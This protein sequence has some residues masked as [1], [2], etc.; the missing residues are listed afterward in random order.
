M[1][2]EQKQYER[3]FEIIEA[4]GADSAKWPQDGAF[5]DRAMRCTK[6]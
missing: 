4:Y 2:P 5:F 6:H 3:A 1:S